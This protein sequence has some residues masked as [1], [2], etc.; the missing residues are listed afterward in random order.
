MKRHGM[1]A[2]QRGL[3]IIQLMVILLVAGVLGS[4]AVRY[5]IDKRCEAEPTAKV[6]ARG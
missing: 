6:C 5:L 3:T 1:P 4:I 2:T